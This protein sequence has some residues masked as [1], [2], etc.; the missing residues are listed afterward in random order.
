VP[1]NRAQLH[2]FRDYRVFSN[3]ARQQPEMVVLEL[4]WVFKFTLAPCTAIQ[5][6]ELCTFDLTGTDYVIDKSL[7]PYLDSI[8]ATVRRAKHAAAGTKRAGM[9]GTLDHGLFCSDR[10]AL[11]WRHCRIV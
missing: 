1:S 7:W 6:T 3:L 4:G 10:L 11:R 5:I 9:M 2:W 8:V